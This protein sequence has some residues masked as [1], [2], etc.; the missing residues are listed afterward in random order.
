MPGLLDFA[1]MVQQL[2]GGLLGNIAAVNDPRNKGLNP[3]ATTEGARAYS[4]GANPMG[5]AQPRYVITDNGGGR[6][7]D[8]TSGKP[9]DFGQ[10]GVWELSGNT[11]N[12]V[13]DTGNNLPALMNK[14][15]ISMPPIKL[16]GVK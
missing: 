1:R 8:L 3:L 2:Q 14:Y 7:T 12:R 10:Y 5:Y 4:G 15:G 6:G 16:R 11:L 13:I 9:M